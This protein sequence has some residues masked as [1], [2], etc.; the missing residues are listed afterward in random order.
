MATPTEAKVWFIT[1]SSSGFGRALAEAV[2]NE[3][4]IVVLTA[5]NT[6]TIKDLETK[7]SGR[8][9]IKISLSLPGA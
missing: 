2:L 1:G 9:A 4:Q 5:R 7:F 8:A 6:K 3:G